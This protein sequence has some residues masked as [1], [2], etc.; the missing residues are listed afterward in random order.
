V[1]FMPPDTEA[2]AMADYGR[3]RAKAFFNS[4]LA[5]IRGKPNDLLSFDQ[6][7]EKLRIGGPIYKGVRP[8]PI[9][10]I[11]GSLNR[12]RD[13]DRAFL[14]T[15]AH[16]ADRWRKISRAFY[17]DVSLPPV[18]LYKVGE[19]YFV[20]DGNHRVSVARDQ[21]VEYID[22]DVRECSVRVPVTAELQPEDLIILGERVEFLMR[23]GLDKLRPEANIELTILGGHDRI[24]EHIAVHRYFMGLDWKRDIGEEEAVGHWYDTVYI[25][26]VHVIRDAG[27]LAVFPDRTEADFYLWVIDHQHYLT[28]ERDQ[29]TPPETAAQELIQHLESGG[30]PP[31]PVVESTS[32]DSPELPGD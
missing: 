4:L 7:K 11:A 18:L 9:S 17:E 12:Y 8:V 19:V 29:L 5:F 24:L 2:R 10:Q 22:A 28:Q 32:S 16:T 20:V 1:L 15:Q 25:P 6:V 27:I 3:V 21:G 14:P 26:I 13:F 23:T 30:Q 31:A